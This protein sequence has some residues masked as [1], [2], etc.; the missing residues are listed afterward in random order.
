[1]DNKPMSLEELS[2]KRTRNRTSAISTFLDVREATFAE[3]AGPLSDPEK[4]RVES[5]KRVQRA[6]GAGSSEK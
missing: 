2:R 5:T 3:A 4:V 6:K 1:M